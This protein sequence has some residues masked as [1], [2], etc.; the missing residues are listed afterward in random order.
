M[1]YD[2]PENYILVSEMMK[3]EVDA[4]HLCAATIKQHYFRQPITANECG[5]VFSFEKH[6]LMHKVRP[7]HVLDAL[8]GP[9]IVTKYIDAI[10]LP[11]TITGVDLRQDHIDFAVA[12]QWSSKVR[13]QVAN[14]FEFTGDHLFDV[15]ICNSGYHH[16][17][18]D[19]KA[20]F[21]VKLYS[22]TCNGTVIISDNFLPSYM[23]EAERPASVNRYY[24]LLHVHN[25][26]RLRPEIFDEI[27]QL[28]VRDLAQEDEFKVSF[29]HFLEDVDRANL[30]VSN[31]VWVWNVNGGG[32][33]I[34]ELVSCNRNN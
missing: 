10:G 12:Q 31:C 22:L 17:P 26:S 29:D 19:L 20:S 1:L 34:V 5:G 18:N 28:R 13:F 24:D 6:S 9:G 30:Q 25:K 15:V 33:C 8:C 21:L 27:E 2:S 7:L 23:S 14:I 11:G 4:L 16:I 3:N 32:T